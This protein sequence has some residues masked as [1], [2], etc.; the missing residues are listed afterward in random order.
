MP[1]ASC[2]PCGRIYVLAHAP[3]GHPCPSCGRIYRVARLEEA[4]VQL[5]WMH[6][7]HPQ[8]PPSSAA[9]VAVLSAVIAEPSVA[10]SIHWA[11]RLREESARLRAERRKLGALARQ[12]LAAVQHNGLHAETDGEGGAA[13]TANG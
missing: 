6:G 4:R 5:A 8:Q 13:P 9:V 3:P 10:D 12:V 11:R 1:L 2:P 7:Q